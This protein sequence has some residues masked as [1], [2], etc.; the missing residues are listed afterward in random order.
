MIIAKIMTYE[1]EKKCLREKFKSCIHSHIRTPGQW[2][3]EVG[4]LVGLLVLES[5]RRCRM[6][7]NDYTSTLF[8]AT[9]HFTTV[10]CTCFIITHPPS[11]HSQLSPYLTGLRAIISS[12]FLSFL[13]RSCSVFFSLSGTRR[14]LDCM[15]L[16]TS[17]RSDSEGNVRWQTGQQGSLSSVS[18]LMNWVYTAVAPASMAVKTQVE[19]D[20]GKYSTQGNI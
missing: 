13:F 4:V 7:F 17:C 6:V 15:S 16:M 1:W 8:E 9:F 14:S 18:W 5:Y 3:H 10:Q 20:G 2:L 12:L 19:E 11:G